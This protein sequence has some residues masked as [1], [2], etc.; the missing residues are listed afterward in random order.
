MNKG[1]DS[2]T[3]QLVFLYISIDNTQTHTIVTKMA[4][5]I[6]QTSLLFLAKVTQHMSVYVATSEANQHNGS[7]SVL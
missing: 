5:D 2:D 4:V 1:S 6:T 7:I 3:T